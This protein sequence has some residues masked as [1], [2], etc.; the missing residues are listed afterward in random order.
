MNTIVRIAAAVALVLATAGVA[1]AQMGGEGQGEKSME[2][3]A[4][5]PQV[6]ATVTG[7]DKANAPQV[8]GALK[9]LQ[10]KNA[11]GTSIPAVSHVSFNLE[12]GAIHV[13][14]APGCSLK[15]SEIEKALT[16]TKVKIDRNTLALESACVV[17]VTAKTEADDSAVKDAITDAKIFESFD[18][19]PT[20]E[21][22]TLEVSVQKSAAKVTSGELN[23]AI[24]GAGEY[25]L[26][27]ITWSCPPSKGEKAA[28]GGPTG[29][30]GEQK[31]P[32]PQG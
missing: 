16:P 20:K 1:S 18:V 29:H 14:V 9:A 26:A 6:V 24:A 4:Q 21:A 3:A 22:T 15:L 13:T 32:K 27:D 30:G 25:A 8:E 28:P 12:K 10:C 17:K 31:P 2:K 7:L 11:E 23:K 19:K 5:K